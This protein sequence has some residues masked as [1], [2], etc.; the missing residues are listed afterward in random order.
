M[1]RSSSDG[2]AVSGAVLTVRVG[3]VELGP[4]GHGA[5]PVAGLPLLLAAE[6][7]CRDGT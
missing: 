2:G 6:S 4:V 7:E 5:A 1:R 3:V